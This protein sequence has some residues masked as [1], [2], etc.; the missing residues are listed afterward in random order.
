MSDIDKHGTLI[1]MVKILLLIE[2]FTELTGTEGYLKKVGFDTI[3]ISNDKLLGQN[4]TSFNPDIIVVHGADR[5][6]SS[7]AICQ[8]LRENHKFNGKIIM[9]LNEGKEVSAEE[10]LKIKVHSV[11]QAPVTP[12]KLIQSVSKLAKMNT[13]ALLDKLHRLG[14]I[15]SPT[16]Q[17][18][19][20][21]NPTPPSSLLIT[22][23]S[24]VAKYNRLIEGIKIDPKSTT[25]PRAETKKRQEE[26][27]KGWNFNVLEEIDE[28]KKQFVKALFKKQS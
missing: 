8:K 7:I 11:I 3:G 4:L 16:T 22:D 2:E 23:K 12:E 28:L 21:K 18:I 9:I 1:S 24:R 15:E 27:K 26:L 10:L 19:S 20:G 13:Q 25:L 5:K 17:V 6:F 14:V